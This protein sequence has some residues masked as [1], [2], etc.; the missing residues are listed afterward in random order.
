MAQFCWNR[1]H[2]PSPDG[3]RLASV[4]SD[5]EVCLW[6]VEGRQPPRV[7]RGHTWTV[8]GVAWRPDGHVLATSGWDRSIRLWDPT[9]ASCAQILRDLDHPD[10]NFFGVA[11]SP[12]GKLLACGTFLQ[13]V[14]VW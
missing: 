2:I 10:T 13:G 7:L 12:D 4:G 11:W 3:T 5:T 1:C 14:R 9:T 6:E 8:Y